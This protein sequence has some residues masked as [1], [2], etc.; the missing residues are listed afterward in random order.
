MR[1][2]YK[3][4]FFAC[5]YV[6]LLAGALMI[7]N[8]AKKSSTTASSSSS[9][10]P[11]PSPGV[12]AV[13]TVRTV[14]A[15]TTAGKVTTTAY[16]GTCSYLTRDTTSCQSAREALGLSGNWL[17]FSCNVVLGLA[18]SSGAATTT[19]ASA[20]YVTLTT[21]DLPDYASNYYPTSSTYSF[22]ANGYTVTGNYSSLYSAYTTT[23]PDPSTNAQQSVTVNIPLSPSPSGTQTM[24]GGMVGIAINGVGIFNNLADA[25]DNIFA[26]AGSFDQC[27]G[28]PA[29]GKYHYHSEPY[30][31]SSN[32]NNLI[33]VMRDGYFIYGRQDYNGTS[34]GS[35][36]NLQIATSTSNIYKYGG[37]TGTDPISN[38]GSTF[39]YH[40]TEWK[41]CY[42][43]S[44]G[45][46]ASDD[47]ESLDTFNT[48]PS[49]SCAGTW[50]DTWFLTGRGN[51][52]VF[53]TTPSGLAGQT[54]G[55]AT[56]GIRYYY[57]TP[58]T[59]TGC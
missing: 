38:T 5:L 3:V 56:T 40:L 32:D 7:T 6:A 53:M 25:T 12:S 57:G 55:Q 41:G 50:V 19:Y 15:N 23:Y 17:S 13:P 10:S 24:S 36:T 46:K 1:K 28:H 9:P 21:V 22:T 20:S 49:G 52:G 37:H 14:D 34:P 11:S 45:V 2:K 47:G 31:I 29:N 44:G 30:S 42:D 8:C 54:P 59:C 33:G 35:I 27:Q 51:G 4:G 43:E 39:H 26:E 18:T 16:G 48:S 58:G